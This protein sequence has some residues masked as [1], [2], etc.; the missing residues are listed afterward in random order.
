MQEYFNMMDSDKDGLISAKK[1]DINPLPTIAAEI[2]APVLI[3][4]EKL[5]LEINFEEFYD[6]VCTLFPVF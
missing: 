5:R 3:E 2:L 6:A 4:M 1:I